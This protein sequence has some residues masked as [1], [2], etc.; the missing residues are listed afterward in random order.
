MNT[1]T[2]EIY[3]TPDEIKR[4]IAKHGADKV[5]PVSEHVARF[6]EAGKLASRPRNLKPPKI[7]LAKK[8]PIIRKRSKQ[9][10]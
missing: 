6:V 5:V 2:G 1:E 4:A 10:R 3:R 8:P 7:E 9:S